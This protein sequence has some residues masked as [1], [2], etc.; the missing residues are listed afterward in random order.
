MKRKQKVTPITCNLK[1]QAV[2]E[3]N[4]GQILNNPIVSVINF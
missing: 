3:I 4:V 1:T 2:N